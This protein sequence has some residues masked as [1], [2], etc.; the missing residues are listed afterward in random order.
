MEK[1]G[2]GDCSAGTCITSIQK[3]SLVLKCPIMW[4]YLDIGRIER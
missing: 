3:I 1:T 2:Y 4:I